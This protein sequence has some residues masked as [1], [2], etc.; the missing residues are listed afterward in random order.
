MVEQ[1]QSFVNVEIL[2]CFNHIVC[3]VGWPVEVL[4]VLVALAPATAV[5]VLVPPDEQLARVALDP[6]VGRSRAKADHGDEENETAKT[7]SYTS[8]RDRSILQT[9]SLLF[10]LLIVLFNLRSQITHVRH[11][12]GR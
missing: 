10:Q 7:V 6:P 4:V 11:Q 5:P 2:D 8:I 12:K 3:R 9:V 1:L